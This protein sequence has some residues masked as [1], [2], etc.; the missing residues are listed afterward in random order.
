MDYHGLGRRHLMAPHLCASPHFGPVS[1]DAGA[2]VDHVLDFLVGEPVLVEL[3]GTA[4]GRTS[5]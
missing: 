1:F 5:S 2:N 4:V 3:E